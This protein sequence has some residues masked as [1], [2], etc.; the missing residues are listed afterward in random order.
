MPLLWFSSRVD[1]QENGEG[2]PR[3]E[4]GTYCRSMVS[5]LFIRQRDLIWRRVISPPLHGVRERPSPDSQAGFQ[6]IAVCRPEVNPAVHSAKRRLIRRLHEA[7]ELPNHAGQA[8]RSADEPNSWCSIEER[9]HRGGC[10]TECN[11]ARDIVWKR[12]SSNEGFPIGI[13]CRRWVSIGF[14]F[15]NRGDR[16]PEVVVVLG[17][18]AQ[19][20]ASAMATFNRAKR[21]AFCCRVFPRAVATSWAM[22][23]Q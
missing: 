22:T 5:G 10:S 6:A 9:Q 18:H 12:G 7:S 20:A 11:M 1:Q 17:I 19:M 4:A 21:R 2:S 16:T 15:L 23:F 13:G 14:T 3:S 8:V